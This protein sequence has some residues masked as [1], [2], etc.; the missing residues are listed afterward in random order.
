MDALQH[1]TMRDL[2]TFTDWLEKFGERGF[3][4]EVNWPN[5]LGRDF[6]DDQKKWNALGDMWYEKAD[7]ASLWVTAFTADERQTYGGFWLSIYRPSGEVGEDG[8]HVRAISAAEDQAQVIEAHAS[9]LR[10]RRGV[11]VSSAAAWIMP[12]DAEDGEDPNSEV[13]PGVYGEDYWY[14]GRN[15]DPDTGQSTFEYLS[16]RGVD[17][18]R[19]PFRWERLQPRLGDELD[20]FEL[21]ELKSS[22]AAAGEVGLKVVLSLQNYGGYW[23]K[24]D[25]PVKKLKLGTP[26]LSTSRLED[27]W[28][29]LSTNFGDDENVIAYD[30]MNEP[31]GAGGIGAGGHDAEERE[32]EAITRAVVEV[33][34]GREDEKWLMIPGYAG[35]GTWTKTHPEPW[36]DNDSRERYMYTAHQYFDSY[37][38]AGTGGGKYRASYEEENENFAEEGW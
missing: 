21:S 27:V 10:F 3:I 5:E 29:R 30:L 4:G 28:A 34:R 6:P 37:Q 24:R 13:N 33:I 9:T 31:A 20:R 8:R 38:G 15:R 26:D 12:E 11:N 23:A 17:I 25:G 19:I 18:V 7:E 36:I 22:V 16:E 32:W 35:I 2:W 14:P 1:H